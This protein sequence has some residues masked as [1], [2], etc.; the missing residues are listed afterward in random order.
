MEISYEELARFLKEANINTYANKDAAKAVSTR[1][2]SDDYHFEKDGLI[3]H[4]TYFGGRN[5]IGGEVVYK[6]DKPVW[7][8]NYYGFVT[9]ESASEKDAYSFLRA[10]LMENYEDII[11]VRGPKIYS[12]DGWEYKNQAEGDLGRFSGVEEISMEGKPVYKAY[13]HG[14]S[15]K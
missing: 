1:E 9:D 14:G 15:I 3:Y 12:R 8:M 5:F 6:N 7:G 2:K 4:D 13:Y 11:P 10:A